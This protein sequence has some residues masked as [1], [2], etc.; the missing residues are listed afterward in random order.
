M[1][2][3]EARW[4][5]NLPK[6]QT[7]EESLQEPIDMTCRFAKSKPIPRYFV[8]RGQAYRVKRVNFFWQQRQ[9]RAVLSYFS[10]QTNQGTY[11][12]C[13]SNQTLSWRIDRVINL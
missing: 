7:S 2:N 3:S 5:R 11:Q 13:F 9:G 4:D 1:F 12:V 6:E 8:W 10:L